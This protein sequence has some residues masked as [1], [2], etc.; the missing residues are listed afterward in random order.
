MSRRHHRKSML[1]GFLDPKN[2]WVWAGVGAAAI[3]LYVYRKELFGMGRASADTTAP[4]MAG[5]GYA[6]PEYRVGPTLQGW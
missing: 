5:L 2:K 1:H 3:T 6:A 4:A